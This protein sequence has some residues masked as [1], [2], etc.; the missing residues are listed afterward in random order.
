MD[1][2]LD[3][4]CGLDVHRD[5]VKACVRVSG[6]GRKRQQ[7]LATFGT[8]TADLLGLRDWLEQWQVTDVAM[9]STVEYWKAV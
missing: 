6:E 2:I 4:V 8:K 7:T 5:M 3:R 1:V 9:E